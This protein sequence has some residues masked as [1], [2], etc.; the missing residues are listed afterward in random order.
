MTFT[1][2]YIRLRQLQ[3]E[4]NGL[5]IYLIFFIGACI[6][7]Q[8][9][10]YRQF[11][12]EKQA[13]Y[14]VLLLAIVCLFIQYKRKDKSFIYKHL[15]YPYL[16]EFAEYAALTLPFA[17]SSVFTKNWYCYP[18]L[19]VLLGIIPLVKPM[20]AK[21]TYFKNLSS[22]IPAVNVEWISGIRKNMI[23]VISLYLVAAC[24]CWLHIVPLFFLWMLTMVFCSFQLES[25]PLQMLREG[26]YPAG[27]YIMRKM[28][29]AVMYIVMLYAPLLVINAV[30]NSNDMLLDILFIFAQVSI[31]CFTICL[32]YAVYKPGRILTGNNIPLAIVSMGSAIPYFLPV[33][34]LLSV[35]YFY[36]ASKHLKQY[37]DD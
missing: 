14:P 3:R 27:I 22:F 9:Y 23:P 13:W 12:N 24:T 6:F 8:Y 21:H 30:I 36:K 29:T 17:I 26:N 16:Q 10:F 31:I 33:P 5:G 34:A 37:L 18:V 2:L 11:S 15:A 32:K 20:A 19:L 4:V 1:L 35:S 28:K 7:L 25:E